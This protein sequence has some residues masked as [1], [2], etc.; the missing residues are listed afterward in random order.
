MK[1][2]TFLAAAGLLLTLQVGQVSANNLQSARS[3]IESQNYATALEQLHPLVRDGNAD[4]SNL[5]GKMYENG[6]GVEADEEEAARLYRL[7]ANQGHLDS[8]TSLRALQNKAYAI[9]YARLLPLA[10]AG[11]AEAQ[12]R[13]G[14]MLEFG[15]GVERDK[16]AAFDWYQLAADQGEVSAW[17][18]LG[19][20][21][22][23]G[24]GVEQDYAVAEQWY[25]Q[26]AE[27]GYTQSLFFLGTLYATDHGQDQ[28][29]SSDII[30]YAWLQNAADLGDRTARP[31][32]ERLLLK[33]DADEVE[34]A[35]QLAE[36]YKAR[37]ISQ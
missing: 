31:I 22:N 21:Y 5:L 12:N 19:R 8:V 23:F 7:G 27:R 32:A 2:S 9:E 16:N 30:A 1:K 13:L 36:R 11:N 14:E 25:R 26:A 3:A 4:A 15:Q 18:N 24:T 29:Y 6:W 35:K 10:E 34:V 37:Y 33:L 20:S 17:H 28:S